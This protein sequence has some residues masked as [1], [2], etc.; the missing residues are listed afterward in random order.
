MDIWADVWQ[1]RVTQVQARQRNVN[2]QNIRRN[3]KLLGQA[4]ISAP[5]SSHISSHISSVP[6]VLHTRTHFIIQ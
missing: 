4:T 3:P 1:I 6:A 5:I 2:A